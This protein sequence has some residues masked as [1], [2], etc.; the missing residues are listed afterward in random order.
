MYAPKPSLGPVAL[1]STGFYFQ[2]N[3]LFL[4]GLILVVASVA[5]YSYLFYKEV[6]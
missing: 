3:T 2:N 4:A 6:K 5:T 1:A